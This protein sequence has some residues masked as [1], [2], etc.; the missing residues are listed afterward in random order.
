MPTSLDGLGRV[1]L[2]RLRAGDSVAVLGTGAYSIHLATQF[3]GPRP[4]V[5]SIHEDGV[6]RLVR[7][8]ETFEDLV[9]RDLDLDEP[10]DSGERPRAPDV[11]RVAG[12]R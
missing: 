1:W 8:R 11:R 7:R 4:A 5:V 12:S 10:V 3:A 6:P 9:G 2:P